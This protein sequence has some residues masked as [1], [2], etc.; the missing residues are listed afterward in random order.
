V[1]G[2]GQRGLRDTVIVYG[3]LAVLVVVI[4]VATGGDVGW[5]IVAGVSAFAVAVGYDAWR[6]RSR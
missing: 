2:P 6:R 1:T 5:A 3:F 4:G